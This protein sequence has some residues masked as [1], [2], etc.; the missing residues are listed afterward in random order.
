MEGYNILINY[1]LILN[2]IPEHGRKEAE[3]Q[4]VMVCGS[5]T[6]DDGFGEWGI[7]EEGFGFWWERGTG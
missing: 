6:G 7:I 5:T 1:N 4:K 2:I 3:L